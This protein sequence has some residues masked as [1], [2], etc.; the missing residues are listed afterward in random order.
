[1]EWEERFGTVFLKFISYYPYC[2]IGWETLGG[3]PWWKHVKTNT[4]NDLLFFLGGFISQ[5]AP[6]HAQSEFIVR[7]GHIIKVFFIF[8]VAMPR[9]SQN[10]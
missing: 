5:S 8:K 10:W 7:F 1:M 6:N 3:K 4:A 9:V 2:W